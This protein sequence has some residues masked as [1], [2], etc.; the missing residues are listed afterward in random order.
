ML[1]LL[2][3]CAANM[4]KKLNELLFFLLSFAFSA[5]FRCTESEGRG[6]D[7]LHGFGQI[8]SFLPGFC[9]FFVFFGHL[10]ALEFFV[11]Y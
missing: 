9:L 10:N 11:I 6:C 5:K 2:V 3:D 7:V 4:F 1:L 8:L